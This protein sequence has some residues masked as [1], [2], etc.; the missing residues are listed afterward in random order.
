MLLETLVKRARTDPDLPPSGYQKQPI[1]YIVRIAPDGQCIGVRDTAGADN[2]NRGQHRLAPHVKRASGI[3]PK[4]L[5][6]NAEYA[7]GI[8]R[9]DPK[10]PPNLDR[11]A[12]QHRAFV[13]LIKEC[14]GSTGEPAVRAVVAFLED[15]SAIEV[16]VPEDFDPGATLTFRV[17]TDDRP[18]GV[19]PID[20]PSVRAFWARYLAPDADSDDAMHCIAC[21]TLGPVLERHPLKITGI[22]GGQIQKDLISA[23]N[24]AFLSYGLKASQIAPTCPDCAEAYGNA[25]N[26][27]LAHKDTS[28]WTKELAYAFWTDDVASD[29]GPIV[30]GMF[31]EPE[32]HSGEIRQLLTAY[33]SGKTDAL[34][35]DPAGFHAVALGASGA[36][37]VVKDWM[38]TTVGDAKAR[39]ARY[40][41]L[42][43]I[44]QWDGAESTPIPV[45]WLANATVHRTATPP[46]IVSSS[47]VRL[48]LAGNPLPKEVLYLAVR[49][50][51]A[52]Q[53]VTRERAALIKMALLSATS[54]SQEVSPMTELTPNETRPAYLC[55]RLLATLDRIQQMALGTPNASI[56][57]K[58][59]GSASSAPASVFGTLIHGA[60]NHLGKLRRDKPGVHYRL[61]AELEEIAAPLPSFPTTLT[62]EEQGLFALGF[63]HQR[64]A[65]R[66]AAR[67]GAEKKRQAGESG[68][69]ELDLADPAAAAIE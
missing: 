28:L 14:A 22:P 40:F 4:L 43:E 1:R 58:Y 49:R 66:A 12:A 63:Y 44:V 59:Y 51:R 24:D 18:E 25:L 10:R 30:V 5:A 46:A 17:V 11:I 68:Q 67:A 19:L 26:A 32:A 42:Q 34:A 16:H 62:L 13:S 15:A 52:D 50:N 9:D 47:L 37:V 3:K 61:E 33:R 45:H 21:G 57:D 36:R 20:L 29:A 39:M 65:H 38:D 64:A 35:V 53:Y 48:A 27:L 60:Q 55:G 7:L 41:A 31:K 8:P 6:D 23:N 54:D 2:R 56:I 69:Q